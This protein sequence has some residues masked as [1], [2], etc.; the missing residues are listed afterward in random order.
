M[1]IALV[2]VLAAFVG[3]HLVL[4]GGLARSRAVGRA[5]GALL[6]PPLAPL[7][8]WEAGLRR[9]TFVWGAALAL[10]V[11]GVALTGR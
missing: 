6:V 10:Y 4:A 3:A 7:W 1:G 11:L 9:T 8:G 5:V 2:V